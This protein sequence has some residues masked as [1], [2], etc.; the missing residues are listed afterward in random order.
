MKL[1]KKKLIELLEKKIQTLRPKRPKKRL[2]LCCLEHLKPE[3]EKA[4]EKMLQGKWMGLNDWIICHLISLMR[5]ISP[6][7]ANK[8][9][10][11]PMY[12]RFC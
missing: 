1:R 12:T 11:L 8:L 3:V 6:I 7:L 10:P 5:P 4:R 2:N 9:S